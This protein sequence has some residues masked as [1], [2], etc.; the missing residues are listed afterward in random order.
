MIF[1]ISGALVKKRRSNLQQSI[2]RADNPIDNE[3]ENLDESPLD[4]GAY[5]NECHP[6]NGVNERDSNDVHESNVETSSTSISKVRKTRGPT[7]KS[8]FDPPQGMKW[9][10]MF[11]RNQPVG[12]PASKLAGTLGLYARNESYFSPYKKWKQQSMQSFNDVMKEIMA[13]Y[14]NF[15]FMFLY[16]SLHLCVYL[17][18]I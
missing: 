17:L 14:L 16:I 9:T 8:A 7:Q 4:N 3:V 18:M 10:C 1:L 12:E 2:L 15:H 13:C 6:S 11:I 5:S